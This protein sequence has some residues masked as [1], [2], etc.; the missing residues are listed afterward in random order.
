MTAVSIHQAKAHLSS[1]IDR[2]E[3][4]REQVIICRYGR[5]VARLEPIT[6]GKRT[7]RDPVLSQVTIHEDLTKPT[8]EEWED[9]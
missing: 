2:V 5:A 7:V 6:R 1:L 9:A 3:D 4:R 8:V